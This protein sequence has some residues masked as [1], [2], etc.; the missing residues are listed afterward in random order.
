MFALVDCNNFYASC[1]RLFNPK[2]INRP[3]IVLS[4][5]DGCVIARSDEA[6]KVGIAM[7]SP[8]F[9]IKDLVQQHNVAVCSSNYTLYGDL[10]DRVMQTMAGMVPRVEI[11]SID[12][13]FLDLKDI[14]YTDLLQLGVQLRKTVKKNTGIPV[15]V[16]IAPTKT[17][18]KMANRYAKKKYKEVGVFWAANT[19]LINEMLSATDIGDVWGIG[20]QY[21]VF[22]QN[23]GFQTALDFVQAPEE[24]I[25]KNMTVVGQRMLNELRGIPAIQ[26]LYE[27]RSK[28]NICTSRSFGKLLTDKSEIKIAVANYAA[29]C[30]AKLRKQ[31]TCCTKVHVFVHTNPHKTE[32]AQYYM[33]IAIQLDIATNSSSEI[34]KQALKGFDI[35]FKPGYRYLKCGV[36]VMDFIP[37]TAVQSSLFSNASPKANTAMKAMDKVNKSLGHEMVRVASQ[38][39]ERRYKLKAEFLSPCY[40]TNVQ[41]LLRIKI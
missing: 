16:G 4:N 32:D 17:L 10:S 18:A 1:E 38:G 35:I 15:S 20:R 14:I 2:L 6:K 27:P 5:N 12:E 24:W 40:T 7:G 19:D 29:L 31:K 3:V 23:H 25:R 36:I 33:S 30:A 9:M 28:K 21:A 41:Q 22:L 26:S 39:F 37:E 11:Y 8:A 13:A 34:I